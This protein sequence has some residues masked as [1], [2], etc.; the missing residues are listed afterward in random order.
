MFNALIRG[1]E[2]INHLTNIYIN[3]NNIIYIIWDKIK[4]IKTPYL[5]ILSLL[6]NLRR[7]QNSLANE[8]SLIG[9]G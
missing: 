7:P 2:G 6:M 1:I 9:Y 3:R 5:R 4:E 8:Y